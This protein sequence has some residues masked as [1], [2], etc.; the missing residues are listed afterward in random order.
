MLSKKEVNKI[1]HEV[2]LEDNYNFLEE[3]LH[4]LANAFVKAARPAIMKEELAQC[5]EIVGN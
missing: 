4:K 5:A 3:D 2:H 1:F